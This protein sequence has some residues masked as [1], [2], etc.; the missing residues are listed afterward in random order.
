MTAPFQTITSR[1]IP[2]VESD[3]DTDQIIP[4]QFVNAIGEDALARSF[5][6]GR[7]SSDPDFVLNDP[8]MSGRKILLV[9]K[10]F[11]CGSSREAAAWAARAWGIRCLIGLSFNPT[12]HAN[13]L[14]NGLLPIAVGEAIHADLERYDGECIVDLGTRFITFGSVHFQFEIDEFTADLLLRGIDELDYL[15]ERSNL[16]AAFEQR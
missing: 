16:I 10:N 14:Q 13:C 3:V 11:G 8:A 7:R 4:A 5:F 9:G 2:L 1:A 15:L 6:A 12:F